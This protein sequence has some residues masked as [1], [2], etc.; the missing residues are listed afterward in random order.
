M[1]SDTWGSV[2]LISQSKDLVEGYYFTTHYA[3]AGA[4]GRAKEFIDE[5][6]AAYGYVPDDVAAL[7]FDAVNIL[8]QAIQDA[9]LTGSL[10]QDRDKIRAAITSI[11]NYEG[12]TGK[13]TFNETG[14][15]E[16]DVVIVQIVHGEFT[17]VT[18][19]H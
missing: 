6:Q 2:D 16:K 9:G 13:M 8:L 14:D 4:V 19:L 3:A 15:P 12:I 18:S 5:Y 7:T 11:K 17:Y 1:G 10:H